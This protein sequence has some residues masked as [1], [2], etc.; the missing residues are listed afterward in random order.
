MAKVGGYDEKVGW[1]S[2][3]LKIKCETIRKTD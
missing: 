2:D 1:I 3:E